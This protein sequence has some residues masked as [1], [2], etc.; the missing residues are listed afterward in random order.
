M[1]FGGR[2]IEMAVV[3]LRVVIWLELC[4][5]IVAKTPTFNL[6][7]NLSHLEQLQHCYKVIIAKAKFSL[8]G[9]LEF[10]C[11]GFLYKRAVN[12]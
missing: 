2:V 6:E 3:C 7:Q 11:L 8:C 9:N 4:V 1:D 12:L 10:A 5:D